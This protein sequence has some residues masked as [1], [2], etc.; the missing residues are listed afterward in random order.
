VAKFSR[1]IPPIAENNSVITVRYIFSVPLCYDPIQNSTWHKTGTKIPIADCGAFRLPAANF[2]EFAFPALAGAAIKVSDR[3]AFRAWQATAKRQGGEMAQPLA[4]YKRPAKVETVIDHALGQD[5]D[6]LRARAR[7]RDTKS[8]DHLPSECLVHL[9][10]KA[11]HQK[12]NKT[13]DALLTLLL[14]RCMANFNKNVIASIPNAEQARCQIL[15]DFGALFALDGTPEDEH[16]AL[17]FFEC[18]FNL[19]LHSFRITHLRQILK[20]QNELVALPASLEV[21]DDRGED[22]L[23]EIQPPDRAHLA[24]EAGAALA[25]VDEDFDPEQDAQVRALFSILCDNAEAEDERFRVRVFRAIMEL[26]REEARALLLVHYRGLKEESLDPN[27]DTAARRCGVTG[28]T[29]RNRI[30]QAKEKLSKLKED[31]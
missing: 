30:K 23:E 20:S 8:P 5:L 4:K 14:E 21:S 7:I 10:R 18:R 3:V 11:H 16:H 25:E 29:I 17:D 28:R 13:R 27:E 22:N 24:G 12:D 9:I 19:A 15:N 31:A 2:F 1:P 26:P 6:T